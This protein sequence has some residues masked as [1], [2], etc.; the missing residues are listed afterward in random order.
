MTFQKWEVIFAPVDIVGNAELRSCIMGRYAGRSPVR[1]GRVARPDVMWQE[2]IAG[3]GNK[4]PT[5]SI[6]YFAQSR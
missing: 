2:S 6:G 5:D 1:R 4:P 3:R